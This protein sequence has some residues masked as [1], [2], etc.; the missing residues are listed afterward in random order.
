M[1]NVI[2]QILTSKKALAAIVSVVVAGVAKLGLKLDTET[3]LLIVGPIVVYI[4]GQ[5]VADHGKEAV[6]A[7]EGA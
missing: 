7:K 6:K 2:K 5:S 3:V 4:A 1:G